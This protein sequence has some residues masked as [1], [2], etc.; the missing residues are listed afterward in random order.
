[1]EKAGKGSPL[2]AGIDMAKRPDQHGTVIDREQRILGRVLVD[3]LGEVRSRDR[4][5]RVRTR[6]RLLPQPVLPVALQM[7]REEAVVFLLR[8]AGQQ[9]LEVALISPT[10]PSVTGCLRPIWVGSASIWMILALSG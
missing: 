2:A 8:E 9:R 3:D 4:G 1:M 10:A 6:F 7:I 5:I